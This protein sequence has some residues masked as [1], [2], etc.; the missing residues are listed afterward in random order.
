MRVTDR[1]RRVGRG[2]IAF[3]DASVVEVDHPALVLGARDPKVELPFAK[4][5]VGGRLF[6]RRP[7]VAHEGGCQFRRSLRLGLVS[8]C[9]LLTVRQHGRFELVGGLAQVAGEHIEVGH[10]GGR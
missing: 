7:H 2:A 10:H 3:G 8:L 4:R 1:Q 6:E 5:S 9:L